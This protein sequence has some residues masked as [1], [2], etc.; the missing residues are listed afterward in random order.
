MDPT[1]HASRAF[2]VPENGGVRLHDVLDLSITNHG[3]ID[4]VVNDYGPPTDANT[5][6]NYVLEYPPGA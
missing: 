6:P 5:T 4:H 3:T 2:A 1:I